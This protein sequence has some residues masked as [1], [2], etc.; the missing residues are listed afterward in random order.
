DPGRRLGALRARLVAADGRLGHAVLH[1]RHAADTRLRNS[2]RRLEALSPLAV[3]ARGYAVCWTAD[4]ARAVRQASDVQPGDAI[5]VTLSR[6]EI[7]AKV[8]G[9]RHD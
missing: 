3:L 9:T 7:D 5:R 2:A 1:R 8:S 4:G 6:G